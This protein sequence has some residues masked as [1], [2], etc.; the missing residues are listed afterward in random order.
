M[1]KIIYL[2]LIAFIVGFFSTS[3]EKESVFDNKINNISGAKNFI[4]R[5]DFGWIH[6]KLLHET[7]EYLSRLGSGEYV[8][9]E[10]LE[11]ILRSSLLEKGLQYPID[12]E[13]VNQ[14]NPAVIE[15]CI[16]IVN[17]PKNPSEEYVCFVESLLKD[18]LSYDLTADEKEYVIV[19]SEV[20]YTC[21][22]L[23]Y[24]FAYN[25][26]K[27]PPRTCYSSQDGDSRIERQIH[28]C[29]DYKMD[30]HL[31]TQSAIVRFIAAPLNAVW[32]IIEC[33]EEIYDGLWDH[34]KT[35]TIPTTTTQKL[36]YHGS[37]EFVR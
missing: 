3:C 6:K 19:F 18:I 22:Y 26:S 32:D 37:E 28:A 10:I 34:V 4:S 25:Q 13:V 27:Q 2:T 31:E 14:M 35:A 21:M 24:F 11:E 36:E 17:H 8:N 33:C 7:I 20:Q 1:K 15:Y 12:T 16:E 29:I 9:Y 30:G 23:T 5:E